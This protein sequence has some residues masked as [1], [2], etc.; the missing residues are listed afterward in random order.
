MSVNIIKIISHR[1]AEACLLIAKSAVSTN[2]HHTLSPSSGFKFYSYCMFNLCV[3]G[4]QRHPCDHSYCIDL[5][6]RAQNSLSECHPVLDS[7]FYKK[8]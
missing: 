2:K 3:V 1:C 6:V 5:K 4:I 8:H 7:H